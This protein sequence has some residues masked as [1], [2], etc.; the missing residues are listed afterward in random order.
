MGQ[1][2]LDTGGYPIHRVARMC[3]QAGA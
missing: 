3:A 1:M 2:T